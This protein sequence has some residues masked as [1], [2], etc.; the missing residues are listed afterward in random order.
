MQKN[1]VKLEIDQVDRVWDACAPILKKAL[2]RCEGYHDIDDIYHRIKDG[3]E[4]LWVMFDDEIKLA[5]TTRI[6]HY[7]KKSVLE[8]PL[9]ATKD[10]GGL[11]DVRSMFNQVEGW[12]KEQGAEAT[13]FFARIGWKKLFPEFKL[14][15]TLMMKDYEV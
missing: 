3:H 1:L 15:H 12:A 13:V 11:G 9:L 14:K 2:D 7:P 6:V 8:I 4:D 5:A 10:N